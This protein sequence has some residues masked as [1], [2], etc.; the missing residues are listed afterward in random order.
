MYGISNGMNTDD[1]EW[2]WRSLLLLQVTKHVAR[3]FCICRVSCCFGQTRNNLGH[4]HCCL[5]S[6]TPTWALHKIL[7]ISLLSSHIKCWSTETDCQL[8]FFDMLIAV[9]LIK[10]IIVQLQLW[11]RNWSC[12]SDWKLVCSLSLFLILYWTSFSS[13]SVNPEGSVP[14]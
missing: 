13:H 6:I 1:L 4:H 10:S 8:W 3:S 11:A 7:S 12:S 9:M 5:A 14:L 2:A